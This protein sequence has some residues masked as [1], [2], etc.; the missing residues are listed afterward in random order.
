MIEDPTVEVFSAEESQ[1]GNREAEAENELKAKALRVSRILDEAYGRPLWY[2]RRDPLSELVLTYLSQ[3]TSDTNSHRAFESLKER[4]PDWE[5]VAEASTALVADAI[6]S[7]GLANQKAPRIQAALKEVYRAEGEY[8]LDRLHGL[9]TEEG[10]AYLKRFFGAGPKTIACVMLF[11]L[12][13][14]VLPVDTHVHR[15]TLRLGLVP[16]KTTADQAHARLQALI[17]PHETYAFHVRFIRH[18]RRICHAQRP[19]CPVCPLLEECPEGQGRLGLI[20]QGEEQDSKLSI[21]SL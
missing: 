13:R 21:E 9:T 20:F 10:V 7:G 17:P 1:A 11:S 2:Y 4:F 16:K 19:E 12:G 5:S 3:A 6:R 14:P 8:S 18:G 15:V